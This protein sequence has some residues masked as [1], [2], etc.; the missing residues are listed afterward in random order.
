MF[1]QHFV[2]TSPML[3][4]KL[5]GYIACLMQLTTSCSTL[6]PIHVFTKSKSKNQYINRYV[7]A[8]ATM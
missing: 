6:V 2:Y 1:Q 3:H 8:K 4:C 5:Q 7:T